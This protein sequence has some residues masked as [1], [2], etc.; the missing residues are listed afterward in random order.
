[1]ERLVTVAGAVLFVA[2]IA[3][4]LVFGAPAFV[5]VLGVGFIIS[6]V[7]TL[8]TRKVPVGVEGHEPSFYLHGGAALAFGVLML[9]LGAALIFFAP[10][11]ACLLGWS[12]S[13]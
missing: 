8:L 9:L 3:A 5:R 4:Y 7:Y 13:C 11:A 6:G 2:G 1:M 10:V 12:K